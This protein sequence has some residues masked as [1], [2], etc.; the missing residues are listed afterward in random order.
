M[1]RDF[2]R[3]GGEA[4]A[5]TTNAASSRHVS[6]YLLLHGIPGLRLVCLVD[7]RGLIFILVSAQHYRLAEDQTFPAA[8]SQQD[9]YRNVSVHHSFLGFRDIRQLYIQQQHWADVL[10]DPAIRGPMSVRVA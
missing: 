9:I 4:V 6:W 8:S 2:I 7:G 1:L 5:D 3:G 10:K